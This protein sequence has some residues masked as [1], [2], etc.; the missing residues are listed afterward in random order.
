MK[1]T[2]LHGIRIATAGHWIPPQLADVLA[3]QRAEEPQTPAMLVGSAALPAAK[4]PG[5]QV[6]FVFSTTAC[7]KS[8]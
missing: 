6:D 3:L 4:F 7:E 5:D 2:T 8:G 1:S